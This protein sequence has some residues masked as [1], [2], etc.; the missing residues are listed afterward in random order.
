MTYSTFAVDVLCRGAVFACNV[1]DQCG[2]PGATIAKW[3][4][5]LNLRARAQEVAA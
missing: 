3:F 1:A 5:R 2:V 4:S